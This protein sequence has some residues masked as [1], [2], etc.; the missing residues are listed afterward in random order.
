VACHTSNTLSTGRRIEPLVAPVLKGHRY[1][2][3]PVYFSDVIVRRD[4]RFEN[5]ADLRGCSWAFN[6]PHSQSGYGIVRH[7][8]VKC[9]ETNGYFGRVVEVGYHER[10][11]RMVHSGEVEAAAID[12]HVLTLMMRD[13]PALAGGIRVIDTLGPSPIQPI[14]A[15]DRLSRALKCE[16]KEVLVEMGND[17]AILPQLVRASV[18]RFVPISD[19]DYDDIRRMHAVA[20]AARFLTI[21]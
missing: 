8:L 7:H 12:S 6:E 3:K 20:V 2:N 4:S 19:A 17:E 1:E 15:A 21:R 9:G 16:I 18:Q 14:V 5:F 10:A 13:H 11:I